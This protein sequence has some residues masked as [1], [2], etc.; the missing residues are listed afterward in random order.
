MRIPM[1]VGVCE[2]LLTIR[3]VIA[4]AG[5]SASTMRVTSTGYVDLAILLN[6]IITT[7]D[8]H[9][10]RIQKPIRIQDFQLR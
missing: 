4:M 5:F 6:Q 2:Y 7:L 8:G 1:V 10:A 9:I 3:N